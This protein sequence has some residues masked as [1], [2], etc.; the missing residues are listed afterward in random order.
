MPKSRCLLQYS[1]LRFVLAI[2]PLVWT[3]SLARL[4]ELVKKANLMIALRRTAMESFRALI[5]SDDITRQ[6]ILTRDPKPLM[7]AELA[8]HEAAAAKARCVP[9]A[10]SHVSVGVLE[11]WLTALRLVYKPL[12]IC[13]Y[14]T[15]RHPSHISRD[16]LETHPR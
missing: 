16:Y 2:P 3:A 7:E 9:Y 1:P 12:F 5:A 4:E 14:I 11:P 15:P 6:L 8:K 13:V 10:C